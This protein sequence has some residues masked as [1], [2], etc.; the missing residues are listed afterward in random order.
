MV[1]DNWTSIQVHWMG[2]NKWESTHVHWAHLL[3]QMADDNWALTQV[4]RMEDNKWESTHVHTQWRTTI[5]NQP[6]STKIIY[7]DCAATKM[8]GKGWDKAYKTYW[9]WAHMITKGCGHNMVG[10]KWTSTHICQAH[11]IKKCVKIANNWWEV[12]LSL[13]GLYFHNNKLGATKRQTTNGH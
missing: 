10:N 9:C 6:M 4:H 1:N 8:V 13:L 3:H 7:W 12:T 5:G 11:L 2:D